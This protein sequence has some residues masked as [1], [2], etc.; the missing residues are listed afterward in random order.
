MERNDMKSKKYIWRKA[1]CFVLKNRLRSKKQSCDLYVVKA[2]PQTG[3]FSNY[4]Y[5]IGHSMLAQ[6]YGYKFVIDWKNY[7]TPYNEENGV[8]G[9]QNCF[10]YYFE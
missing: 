9:T 10:E 1:I 8:N 4:F 3:F 7:V 6:N 5:A 2:M